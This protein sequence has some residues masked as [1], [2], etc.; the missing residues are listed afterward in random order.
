[1]TYDEAKTD[2]LR[3]TAKFIVL[4]K[5]FVKSKRLEERVRIAAWPFSYCTLEEKYMNPFQKMIARSKTGW[6][7][8]HGCF[9]LMVYFVVWLFG[10]GYSED[11]TIGLVLVVAVHL[12]KFIIIKLI[13]NDFLK[14]FNQDYDEFL[15]AYTK[16]KHQF[17]DVIAIEKGYYTKVELDQSVYMTCS[18]SDR[19]NILLNNQGVFGFISLNNDYGNIA[20]GI[21][22]RKYD[23]ELSN[24]PINLTPKISAVEFREHYGVHL[25]SDY[26]AEAVAEQKAV[27]YLS[28][29]R[30]LDFINNYSTCKNVNSFIF[31]GK[32]INVSFA[33][34]VK[35]MLDYDKGEL[36]SI[37][38]YNPVKEFADGTEHNMK[39]LDLLT[40]LNYEFL[41]D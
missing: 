32:E 25:K 11:V 34:A 19:M 35:E 27:N 26:A 38:D 23:R 30:I 29:T 6:E 21:D 33:P 13:T 24:Y 9:W 2:L 40:N 28:P 5:R 37:M 39:V 12:I 1:M 8:T 14:K 41:E 15:E 20:I 10:F 36:I 4:Q 31:N 18:I 16:S 7:N 17:W 3:Y 22:S